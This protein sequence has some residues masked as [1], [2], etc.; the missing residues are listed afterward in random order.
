MSELE[1][2]KNH[3]VEIFNINTEDGKII[4][5]LS[6]GIDPDSIFYPHNYSNI[7]D[8]DYMDKHQQYFIKKYPHRHHR[9]ILVH[10]VDSTTRS[11][12]TDSHGKQTYIVYSFQH[13]ELKVYVKINV[14][15]KSYDNEQTADSYEFVIPH[16]TTDTIY[17]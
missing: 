11:W 12:S 10:I 14:T 7:L 17:E 15:Y 3:L 16:F 6:D 1:E 9:D 4:D 13:D 2:F 8:I 5:I